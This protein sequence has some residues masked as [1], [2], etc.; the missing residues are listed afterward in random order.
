M[1]MMILTTYEKTNKNNVLIVGVYE[2]PGSRMYL[3]DFDLRKKFS[4]IEGIEIYTSFGSM[5]Y[6]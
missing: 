6:L 3:D 4:N 5:L 1:E 2:M